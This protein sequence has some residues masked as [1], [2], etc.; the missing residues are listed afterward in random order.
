MEGVGQGVLQCR[1]TYTDLWPL[2]RT[3]GES[4][5]RWAERKGKEGCR[6]AV[7]GFT[8]GGEHITLRAGSLCGWEIGRGMGGGRIQRKGS[9]SVSP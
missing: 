2:V 5:V 7:A 1:G 4:C 9:R 3:L 6:R 8:S